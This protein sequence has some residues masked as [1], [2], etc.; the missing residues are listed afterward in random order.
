MK[1]TEGTFKRV[2]VRIQVDISNN[3]LDIM[4]KAVGIKGD[5]PV[6]VVIEKYLESKLNES[7]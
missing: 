7:K 5:Y 3:R 2:G 6:A 1:S 4:K